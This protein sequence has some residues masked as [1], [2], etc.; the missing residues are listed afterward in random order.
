M[1][2]VA[3]APAVTGTIASSSEYNKVVANANQLNNTRT[4][5]KKQA[6]TGVSATVTNSATDIAGT[7]MSVT[8]IEANTVIK[9]TG[10]FDVDS[11]VAG[12][13][14]LGTLVVNGG[15]AEP[16]E[17]HFRGAGRATCTQTWIVTL[18]SVATHSIKLQA[19]KAGTSSTVLVFGVHSCIVAEGQGIS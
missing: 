9:V 11:N 16:G 19:S 13:T 17:A 2:F 7:T 4:K 3:M 15:A 18:A 12:D 1:P 5:Y 14:F 6:G 10:V 8:T